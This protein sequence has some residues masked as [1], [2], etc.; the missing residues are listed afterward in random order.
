M[1]EWSSAPPLWYK[2]INIKN[3]NPIVELT[4][5]FSETHKRLYSFIKNPIIDID[6][7]KSS[8][9][10]FVIS[11]A[12]IFFITRLLKTLFPKF[13]EINPLTLFNF[14]IF[15]LMLFV[16]AII[17]S[18]ILYMFFFILNFFKKIENFNA[19][20]Y[21]GFKAYS[22][23]NIFVIIP[24]VILVNKVMQNKLDNW[25]FSESIIAF[26]CVISL[27]YLSYRLLIKPIA[28]FIQSEFSKKVSYL[29]SF[30]SVF[31]AITTNQPIFENYFINIID[32]TEFCKQY[33]ELNY[34]EEITTM[35]KNKDCM[36]GKCIQTID[37]G[38][39]P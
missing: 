2:G 21:Q 38:I 12:S 10:D 16:N 18:V 23:M 11:V 20:F 6:N 35:Q 32:K 1:T 31:I 26:I 9:L 8:L 24:F 22:I 4:N 15:A 17:F 34:K 39:T 33:I 13:L 30:L 7:V 28:I 3:N 29:I 14:D 27:I 19:I 36:I 37:S 25:S 5:L